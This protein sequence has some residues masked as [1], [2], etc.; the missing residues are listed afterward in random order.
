MANCESAMVT[1]ETNGDRAY[2]KSPS[3]FRMATSLTH[4]DLPFPKMVVPNA[5]N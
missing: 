1:M 5:P 4:C 2:R 3:L